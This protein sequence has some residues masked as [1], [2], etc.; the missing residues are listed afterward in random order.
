MVSSQSNFPEVFLQ[1]KAILQEFEPRLK[2]QTD[3]AEHYSLNAG[4]S[5]KFRKELF[6][7][8]VQIGKSYV[9]YHLFP[10]YMFP[11]L[12]EDLSPELRP[13]MQGKSCFNF[14]TLTEAQRDA[15]AELTR[16]GLE[17]CAAAGLR[18][19]GVGEVEPG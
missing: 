14:R 8:G 2:V 7:G 9:S 19:T 13:R 5:E 6:F 12:L 11:D 3:T 4:Y 10:V 18:C 1:L 15:L 17:R 16:R